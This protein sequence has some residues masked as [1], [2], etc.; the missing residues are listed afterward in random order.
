MKTSREDGLVFRA[1]QAPSWRRAAPVSSRGAAI[2]SEATSG[3]KR[4][5]FDRRPTIP[6]GKVGIASCLRFR[7]P[8]M[9]EHPLTQTVPCGQVEEVVPT[10][11]VGRVG[12]TVDQ[13]HQPKFVGQ[14]VDGRPAEV[15]Q[16]DA[17]LDVCQLQ[18]SYVRYFLSVRKYRILLT[19]CARCHHQLP[20]RS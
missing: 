4:F 15:R 10:D 20:H 12:L 16:K 7:D 1:G 6:A 17:V 13:R 11:A 5:R 8:G 19:S 9:P 2:R 3:G 14:F 18:K